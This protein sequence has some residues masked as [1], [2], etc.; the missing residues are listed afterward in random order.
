MKGEYSGLLIKIYGIVQ[1]VGFRP[2]VAKTAREN[3]ITGWVCNRGSYVEIHGTGKSDEMENFLRDLR[4]KA[5]DRSVILKIKTWEEEPEI[6]DPE[7][8]KDDDKGFHIVS[9]RKDQGLVFVSP[10]IATCPECTR[11]LFD[12][13]DRRYLHPF[14]NCTSCGPRL[15][16]LDS[17]PYDRERTSMG[18][19]PM[20]PECREE[21]TSPETRRY[22]AQPVCCNHCGP[23]LYFLEKDGSRPVT[24]NSES[25]IKAREIIRNGGIL[26]VKGIGG[27]HLCCD[28]SDE[29]AVQRLRQLKHR[30][31]KPF[32]VMMKN[33]E[34]VG[35]ECRYSE[36]QEKLLTGPQKPIILLEKKA[37]G[38]NSELSGEPLAAPSVAPGNPNM[39][40]M[41]PY[42][43]VQMLL[44]DYPD[45]KPMTDVLV[46]TSGN[47][48]GAPISMDD[49]EAAE[50]LSDLSDGIISNGRKIRIRADDTVMSFFHD[51]PYMIR[52]SRGYAPL[53]VIMPVEIPH[54]ILA[55]GGELK[56]TFCL[57][58]EDMYYLSP[59]IGDVADVRTIK[60]LN[61]AVER[62]ERLLEIEPEAVVCDLHPA[63]HSVEVAEKMAERKKIP[64]FKVQHHYAHVA[65]C[66]AENGYTDPV[67]GVSYDGTGYG[68]DGTIWG[69]EILV[70][71]LEGYSREGSIEPFVHA[72]GDM[73]SKEGWRIAA[74]MD[75]AIA[76]ELG[77]GTPQG[78][79]AIEFMKNRGVNA[80][81]STSCGRLFDSIS[82][83]LGVRS[84]STY[85]GQASMELQFS[86]EKMKT[87]ED[88]AE[89]ARKCRRD[90][91]L[92][93]GLLRFCEDQDGEYKPDFTMRTDQLFRWIGRK[94]SE[95]ADDTEN[96]QELEKWGQ[97]LAFVFH[98][99]LADMTVEGCCQ[100]RSKYQLETVALSG[101]VM[102]NTL[103][104]EMLSD[105]L[106]E[107]G[108]RVLLHSQ[109]PPNDGG[110]SLGQAAIGMHR[111]MSEGREN[112]Y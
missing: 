80:V 103:L 57:G 18:E 11:E 24:G 101:G 6:Q 95:I 39:G 47:P 94:I 83:I 93:G 105:S 28:A 23:E 98:R 67:I 65:S 37:Y 112:K 76:E 34:T 62:M 20:C 30:D 48:S 5:P 74:S 12:P 46:M 4:E 91:S 27:F 68:P 17:M 102:Q 84:N 81:R 96:P 36:A 1:G 59:Y 111:M 73:A 14:I 8:L 77:L 99:V 25:I 52:R 100:V 60:A 63:Y 89:L 107:K 64:L 33:M 41:L 44:F 97:K 106:E 55:V 38:K 26:A 32:A 72:G 53:P 92:S 104:V 108:F 87:D 43:P 90:I 40:V 75:S 50:F 69:G 82:A 13:K 66:M 79:K 15:T 49:L 61:Q 110:I 21:Y 3:G 86:A 85:E 7:N 31:A 56:N 42:A 45:G 78:R 70:A 58:K 2:F 10:D 35:R 9:S 109:V 71:D 29:E 54:G 19:F 88:A 16:I 22:H 51:R